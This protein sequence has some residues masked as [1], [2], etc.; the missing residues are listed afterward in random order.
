LKIFL[1]F[2]SS[3]VDVSCDI[4]AGAITAVVSALTDTT[5][6]FVD[7]ITQVK[8]C[9]L[10]EGSN[11][12]IT[13]KCLCQTAGGYLLNILTKAEFDFIKT[14][15]AQETWIGLTNDK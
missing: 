2:F 6:C 10:D 13:T 11:N 8:S 7:P 14:N 12:Y 4:L 9:Y 1:F 5:P 3:Q 15:F